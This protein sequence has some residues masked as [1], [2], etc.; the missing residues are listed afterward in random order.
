MYILHPSEEYCESIGEAFAQYDPDIAMEPLTDLRHAPDRIAED[1]SN[2]IAVGVD[3]P[4][5]PALRAIERI[6]SNTGDVG[7]IVISKEPTQELLVSCMRAGADEFL[8]YPVDQGELSKALEGLAKRKGVI[9][10]RQGKVVAL[11][12]AAGGV[13]CTTIACNLAANIALEVDGHRTCALLD[14][15]TQFGTVALAMNIGEF[16][17]TL[18]DA[19]KDSD[20]LDENLLM[21]MMSEHS[22]GAAVLPSPLDVAELESFDPLQVRSVIATARKTYR[23]VV[24]DMPHKIDEVSIAGLEE[25]DE[26]FLVTDMVVPSIRNTIRVLETLRELEYKDEK[27]KLIISKYYDSH[28]I[29]LDEI[30]THVGIPIYWLVPYDSPAAIAAMNSGETID[31]VDADSQAGHSLV[32]LGQ[33]TAGV[34]P[35]ARSKRKRVFWSWTR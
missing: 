8:E 9:S 35:K 22:S 6:S 17:H 16:S 13:G 12:S 21:G 28:Q 29:S 24:L 19:V 33:T 32:A 7:I 10:T 30:A 26:I 31:T 15:N 11:F 4:N 5:D 18:A 25:A 1:P 27:V 20:R 2:L 23:H 14:M 3:D 34:V